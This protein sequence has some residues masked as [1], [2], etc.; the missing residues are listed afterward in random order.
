MKQ[1]DR[2]FRF[3]ID[4]GLLQEILCIPSRFRVE[5]IS[6]ERNPH[7]GQI[8]ALIDMVPEN[9]PQG[10][11]TGILQKLQPTISKTDGGVFWNWNLPEA[12]EDV[13][14]G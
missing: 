11:Q 13:H 4:L 7:T 14:L 10:K 2:L 12:L 5:D 3:K 1:D 9:H 6:C 8:H